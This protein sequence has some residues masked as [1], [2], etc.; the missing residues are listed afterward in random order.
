MKK[1]LTLLLTAALFA[2]CGSA[3]TS[4]LGRKRQELDSLKTA[5]KALGERIKEVDAWIAEHDTT[6]RRNLAN[7]TAL[8][9]K[10]TRFEH[11]VQVHGHVKADKS[12]DLYGGG[13]RVRRILVQEGDRVSQG[14]LLVDLDND[15]IEKQMAQ[16]EAAYELAR[17]VFAKQEALWKQQ[18]GSEVQ[19]LQAK[20]NKE[21]AE[22]G[23]AAMREQLRM[24]RITA[25]FSGTVDEIMVTVGQMTAPQLPVARVVD[26]AGASLEAEV[27][28][29][30]LQRVKAGDPVRVEFP[31]LGDTIM[32]SLSNVSRYIDPANRTFKV[33][34][35][36]PAGEGYVRPNLL[37]VVH[38]RDVVQD[39]AVVVPARCI[40]ED[41][42]GRSY[43]FVLDSDKDGR[44]VTRKVLV[45]RVMDYRGL[46]MVKRDA[47][48]GLNGTETIV[49]EGAKSVADGQRVQVST[50]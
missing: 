49:D 35:R 30:Y 18:I 24:S 16:A 42:E 20:S 47:V 50:L 43:V 36:M 28:E 12:A 37:S 33:A 40:Q 46:T 27:P 10:P 8:T 6:V 1:S 38:I 29:S 17:D 48:E 14:Q 4:D 11:F 44:Q 13:G 22:A 7:V 9:L 5:Y 26:L 45:D 25:P 23:L 19:Y 3:D 21:Q 2:A 34:L 41:V 31:S 32:A 15:A 39:S